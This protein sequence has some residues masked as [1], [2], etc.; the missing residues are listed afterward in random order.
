MV[1]TILPFLNERHIMTFA[2]LFHER[3]E[4]F[5]L[6]DDES[7][8]PAYWGAWAAYMTSIQEAGIFT[9]GAGLLPPTTATTMRMNNGKAVLH[10]GPFAETKEMLGGFV[11]INVDTIDE[12]LTWASRAPSLNGGSVEVRPVLPPMS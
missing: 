10:D 11:L 8:A 5:D 3:N 2:L 4:D 9:A 6:R 12:A 7:R 1:T